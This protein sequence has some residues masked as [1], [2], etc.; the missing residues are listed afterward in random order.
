[1]SVGSGWRREEER[2]S[3]AYGSAQPADRSTGWAE[4]H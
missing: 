1:V 4:G 3:V 2:G